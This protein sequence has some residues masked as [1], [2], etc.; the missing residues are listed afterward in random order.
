[1]KRNAGLVAG[2]FMVAF[3]T[4]GHA[5]V[6]ITGYHNVHIAAP[7]PDAAV[8]WYVEHLGAVKTASGAPHVMVGD[9]L[10][11]FQPTDEVRPSAGS[12]IDHI[13]LSVGDL[14]ATMQALDGSGATVVSPVRD[15]PGLFKLAFIED[16]WGAKI[17][18]VEDAEWPGFHHVHLRV[19]DPA[20]TLTWYETMLGGAREKLKG[21]I[22]GL[23]YGGVWLLAADSD[24]ET[25][26]PSAEAG[27][28]QRRLGRRRHGRG[29][30]RPSR[31]RGRRPSSSRS[32][33]TRW[34]RWPSSR[35]RTAVSVELL[36]LPQ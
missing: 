34:S 15:V 25:V 33:S 4:A 36:Q 29:P 18:L 12:V 21:R 19:P 16:P 14:E 8:A 6:R 9:T 23:R 3:L 1:M 11:A 7:D 31:R 2:L 32:W 10:I 26:A 30:P 24:G 17:E 20:A 13:G 22:E 28:P 5:A 27:D 35:T